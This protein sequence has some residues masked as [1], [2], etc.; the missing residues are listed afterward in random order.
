MKRSILG[1]MG[2]VLLV[3]GLCAPAAFAQDKQAVQLVLDI[4]WP[5]TVENTTLPAGKYEI[6]QMRDID[7]EWTIADAKGAVKVLFSTE[8]AEMAKPPRSYEATFDVVG[9]HHFLVNLWLASDTGGFYIPMTKSEKAA[10][11][12]GKAKAQEKVTLQKK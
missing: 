3:L 6:N 2:L 12:Q 4:P 8:P 1:L 5:F 10:W 9:D 11:K 7:W